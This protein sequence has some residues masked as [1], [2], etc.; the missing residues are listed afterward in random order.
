MH[1]SISDNSGN[2]TLFRLKDKGKVKWRGKKS[3]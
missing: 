2:Q 3:F 1:L